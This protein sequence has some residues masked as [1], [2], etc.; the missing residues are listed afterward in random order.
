MYSKVQAMKEQGFTIRQ[1][2]KITRT[3]R[4]TVAKYWEMLPEEFAEKYKQAYRITA[5]RG[6]EPVVVAWL[7]TYPCMTAAQVCDWLGEK[8][9]LYANERTVRKYV[10]ELRQRYGLTKKSEP[11]RQYEAV[12]EMP[13]GYQLQMDFGEKTVRN[14]Y[15]S[16][17]IKLYFVAFTLSH[18]RYKWGVFQRQ[19][20]MARDVVNA[21]YACFE[22]MGGT[23]KQLVYDQDSLMVVSENGGD[24]IHTQA[25]AAFLAETK[26]EILVCRKADP[27]T[28]GKIES[29]VKFV[30]GNFMENRLFMDIETWNEAFE[31]WLMRTGNRKKHGTTKRKPSEMFEEEQVHLLPLYGVAPTDIPE[32][33]ERTVRPDNTILYLSNRY[34]LP[35]G[36]YERGKKVY[37]AVKDKELEIMD[38][39][40]ETL[41]K[42][43]IE[44]GVGKLVKHD[45]HR[46]KRDE[47]NKEQLERTIALLGEEFCEYLTRM[48]E[49]KP[50]Y[51]KDQL[52]IVVQACES[53]GRAKVLAGMEYCQRLGL[54]S[55]NDLKNATKAMNPEE[56]PKPSRLTH[57]NERYYIPVQ[58]REL[59]IYSN[60]TAKR[61]TTE[62]DADTELPTHNGGGCN[63]IP[64]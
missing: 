14:A 36:T 26:L 39:V 38:R 23:P 64:S 9:K 20:F 28:K 52:S 12:D 32:S 5:L 29:T 21:L 35:L 27:E 7:E 2:A 4:D 49:E 61:D 13:Q 25:F 50:R 53:Y 58:K 55:A 31:E 62:A 15:S 19:Q 11:R 40:G 43:R 18:S 45:S 63:E 56:S 8:H 42:H 44:K 6:Y 33:G 30:K 57:T 48:C 37:I 24:I 22:Y 54:Y 16:S 47:K 10:A 1:V 34:S 60:V 17:Y 46:R 51:V 41:A 59:S 3:A